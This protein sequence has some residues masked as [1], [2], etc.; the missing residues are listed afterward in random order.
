[1]LRDVCRDEVVHRGVVGLLGNLLRRVSSCAMPAHATPAHAPAG[2]PG[3]CRP[4]RRTC[5][6]LKQRGAVSVAP[7][8]ATA[9]LHAPL[10]RCATWNRELAPAAL[11]A[12]C[13]ARWRSIR[14]RQKSSRAR[15]LCLLHPGGKT[16]ACAASS[17]KQAACRLAARVLG[18]CRLQAAPRGA[19]QAAPLCSA[20]WRLALPRIPVGA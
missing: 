6:V 4:R 10:R 7:T 19:A 11:R 13:C 2:S 17:G 14:A 15:G 20:L 1:M 5:G 16:C 3:A 18:R 12:P 8:A 9:P